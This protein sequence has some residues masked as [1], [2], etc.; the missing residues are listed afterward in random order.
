MR[1][2]FRAGMLVQAMRRWWWY[3]PTKQVLDVNG[4]HRRVLWE[5]RPSEMEEMPI[6]ESLLVLRCEGVDVEFYWKGE[7]YFVTAGDPAHYEKDFR[8]VGLGR[9]M[10]VEHVSCVEFYLRD[11]RS[12]FSLLQRLTE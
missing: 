1:N 3:R 5:R 12:P 11:G 7:V 6:N 9:F 4:D 2:V 8:I 10:Q